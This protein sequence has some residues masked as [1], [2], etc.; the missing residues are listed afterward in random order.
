MIADR[1]ESP[2]ASR[3]EAIGLLAAFAGIRLAADAVHGDGERG[4]RFARDRA[5][6]HRSGSEAAHDVLCRLDLLDRYRLA[7]VLIRRFEPEQAADGEEALGLLVADLGVGPVLV[8]QVAA[9]GVLKRRYRG[10][11]PH[12]V[13]A[14]YAKLVFAADVEGVAIDQSI[15]EGVA[16]PP[17][18][19]LGDLGERHAFD[20]GRG[21]GEILGD[22]IRLEADGVENL[23]A[24]IGLVSGDAHL[25]HHLEDAFVDRLD[26]A[27]DD[28]VFVELAREI[29][30]HRL[31]RL[32]GEIGV[33]RLRAVAG[34]AAEVMDFAGFAGFDDEPDR[35]A[36]T[37][38]DEVVMHRRAGEQRRHRNVVRPGTA[39]RQDDDVDA[40][41]HGGL[42][43][44]AE[45][46]ER[47]LQTRDAVL[48]RPSA[49]EG[50][51]LEMAV[52]DPRDGADLFEIRVSEDRLARFQTLEP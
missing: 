50:A 15:A 21:A 49:V 25:G 12:M 37:L 19:L 34:Q 13:L 39:I 44:D 18:G 8:G 20:A 9:Y 16:V 17:Y 31:Q 1:M 48:G 42:G 26:V 3:L 5:E 23:G 51:G 47:F 29:I 24:A 36:Q 11:G 14:A 30:L 43:A 35:G 7:S 45:R 52:A 2:F 46:V 27:L 40:F 28:L 38:A 22:E 10:W 41:A 6:R 33:D 4:M 32:E